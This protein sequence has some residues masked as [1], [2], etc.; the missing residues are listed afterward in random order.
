MNTLVQLVYASR[1]VGGLQLQQLDDILQVS[2]RNNEKRGITGALCYC[3]RG[4]LQCLEGPSQAVNE[5]YGN[6]V[7]DPRHADVTLLSYGEIGQ[8]SFARWAMAYVRADDI[9]NQIVLKYSP[10]TPLDPFALLARQALGLLV[11]MT[12]QREAALAKQAAGV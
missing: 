2:R 12:V 3:D 1:M 4:F 6:I 11:D 9:D 5:L 8:R 7:R 10:Q